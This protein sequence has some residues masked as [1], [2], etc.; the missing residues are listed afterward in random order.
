[1]R[2]ALLWAL[3]LVALVL[4]SLVVY[5][6][7]IEGNANFERQRQEKENADIMIYG[8]SYTMWRT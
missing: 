8:Q 1:M 7:W 5:G 3:F 6:W 2:R 4:Y